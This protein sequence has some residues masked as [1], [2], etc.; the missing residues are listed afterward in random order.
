MSPGLR[1]GTAFLFTGVL[2]SISIMRGCKSVEPPPPRIQAAP[3]ALVAPL[4]M[5][6][7]Q[8]SVDDLV[9]PIALYPDRLVA[10]I[11]VASMNAREVLDGRN[12]LLTN[13]NLKG[14]ALANAARKAGF[15]PGMQYLMSF[16]DVVDNMCRQLDWTRELGQT[17]QSDPNGILD[18]VQ[19]K[20]TGAADRHSRILSADDG[21]HPKGK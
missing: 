18:A 12:W 13:Q 5:P 15:S 16:P 4:S 9:A 19:R 6:L 7:Q 3:P 20:R 1:A 11:L 8:I 21:R 2:S 14:D 17:F 10:Q